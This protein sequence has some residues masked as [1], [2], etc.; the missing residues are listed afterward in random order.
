MM[1]LSYIS[2]YVSFHL[3]ESVPVII[4]IGAVALSVVRLQDKYG[5]HW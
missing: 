4:P 5:Q 3:F 2:A 1:V